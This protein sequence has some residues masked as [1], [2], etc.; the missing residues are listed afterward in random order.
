MTLNNKIRN[1]GLSASE[2]HFSRDSHDHSNLVLDDIS[3]SNQQMDLRTQNHPRVLKSRTNKCSQ[4]PAAHYNQG[5]LVY[6]KGDHSKH[7]SM[8][9]HI[10][11]KSDGSSKT[12][13]K[14]ALHS[15]SNTR[16]PLTFSA[17]TRKIDNKFLFMPSPFRRSRTTSNEDN[18]PEPFT[19]DPT[20]P[21]P[22][23]ELWSPFDVEPQS[24]L[25]PLKTSPP[26]DNLLHHLNPI[27]EVAL[28]SNH[29][30]DRE[31]SPNSD[32][33]HL[34]DDE[35]SISDISQRSLSIPDADIPTDEDIPL[36]Q[37][38]KPKKGDRISYF[39]STTNRWIDACITHNL[40]RRYKDYYNIITDDGRRDGLYLAPDTLWT[41]RIDHDD[42]PEEQRLDD[43][44]PAD[45]EP[46]PPFPSPL[47]GHVL[48]HDIAENL[49][50]AM[51]HR[52]PALPS[53]SPTPSLEW[54][55]TSS[56]D[57]PSYLRSLPLDQVV[58]LNS[59]LPLPPHAVNHLSDD[60]Y[61]VQNLQH[62]LPPTS[63]PL[64][65]RPRVSNLRRA[66]PI[67]REQ[68]Q[69]MQLPSFLHNLFFRKKL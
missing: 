68:A 14:K 2:I 20:I 40:S 5:D 49:T 31:E 46:S 57:S 45:M 42:S 51:S 54:D 60:P 11:L 22:F 58:N 47:S 38:R 39:D 50:P 9:P 13:V 67:E 33:S 17:Q 48:S 37:S 30:D 1:R 32:H 65:P 35:D 12:V 29:I 41:L 27:A 16:G 61:V 34:A 59:V 69:R 25:I 56:H 55:Y 18:L 4:P 64:S 21:K 24:D 28:P 7:A 10:V 3:L 66:L 19:D 43:E 8:N 15:S 44:E 52:A 26:E 6:V 53:S 63:T 36:D 62:R 23:P